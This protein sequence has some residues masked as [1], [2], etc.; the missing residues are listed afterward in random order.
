MEQ[1]VEA[2]APSTPG[3]Y[4]TVGSDEPI[5]D[6]IVRLSY[7]IPSD[8]PAII[9]TLQQMPVAEPARVAL[10]LVELELNTH[11]SGLAAAKLAEGA[12]ISLV[13]I[14]DSSTPTQ[15]VVDASS[16]AVSPAPLAPAVVP[17]TAGT[18]ALGSQTGWV[19][20]S[21][22]TA[23]YLSRATGCSASST[24]GTIANTYSTTF[25]PFTVGI[26]GRSGYFH[27][28]FSATYNG[29]PGYISGNTPSFT[30][31]TTVCKWNG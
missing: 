9:A 30:C 21:A 17:N 6:A 28:G 25:I 29:S 7:R 12:E 20:V 8:A 19:A 24:I 13:G 11:G 22:F 23:C 5:A 16:T 26:S 10:N 1:T 27:T 31:S 4:V 3:F 15:G 2:V 14:P 18:T